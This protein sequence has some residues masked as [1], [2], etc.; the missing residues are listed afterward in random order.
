MAPGDEIVVVAD[1]RAVPRSAD[2]PSES[3]L[4]PLGRHPLEDVREV[5]CR[6]G[7]RRDPRQEPLQG[8][9]HD[10]DSR[11]ALAKSGE[12]ALEQVRRHPARVAVSAGDDVLEEV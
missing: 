1:P 4:V 7:L 8:L 9:G 10:A 12:V 6:E 11:G 3:A 5:E 2:Y